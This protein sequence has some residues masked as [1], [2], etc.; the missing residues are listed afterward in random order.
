MLLEVFQRQ[1]MP[2]QKEMIVDGAE[3]ERDDIDLVLP[4]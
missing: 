4:S 3:R 2:A 1:G